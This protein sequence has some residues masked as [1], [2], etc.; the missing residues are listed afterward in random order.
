MAPP[1]RRLQPAQRPVGPRAVR[2]YPGCIARSRAILA[3]VPPP[4]FGGLCRLKPAFQTVPAT[5]GLSPGPQVRAARP[6]VHPVHRAEPFQRRR[7]PVLVADRDER[8]AVAAE[9]AGGGFGDL[10]A[11]H[12]LDAVRIVLDVR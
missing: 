2:R 8:A 5:L 11:G 10:V 4:A 9:M 3:T 7:Q 1:A 12:R 6:R